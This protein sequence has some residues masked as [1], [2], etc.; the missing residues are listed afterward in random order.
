MT[1]TELEHKVTRLERKIRRMYRMYRFMDANL[2][3]L[4]EWK[5]SILRKKDNVVALVRVVGKPGG[6]EMVEYMVENKWTR[7]KPK[8]GPE[9]SIRHPKKL[10]V[11]CG[12]PREKSPRCPGN[13]IRSLVRKASK[14]AKGRARRSLPPFWESK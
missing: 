1:Q 3:S 2:Y 14:K 13:A 10:K 7:K 6:R 9:G 8:P 4:A 11:I 12:R 5:P